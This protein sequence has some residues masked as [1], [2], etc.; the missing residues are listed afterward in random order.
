M[1][2]NKEKRVAKC[3][4][5]GDTI[6]YPKRGPWCGGSVCANGVKAGRE[7]MRGEEMDNGNGDA[8]SGGEVAREVFAESHLVQPCLECARLR[9]ELDLAMKELDK[10]DDLLDSKHLEMARLD[11]LI[12][13]FG[14][15]LLHI[16]KQIEVDSAKTGTVSS[17]C[18]VC[19]KELKPL[20]PKQF[21][22]GAC[23]VKAKRKRDKGRYSDDKLDE[24][25]KKIRIS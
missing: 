15:E 23:R 20:R 14:A 1:Y 17:S 19:G 6:K 11:E 9:G 5:C 18:L 13:K 24:L 10:R 3:V 2:G 7:R 22:S 12:S 8:V 16:Q 21:C 25:V 4:V